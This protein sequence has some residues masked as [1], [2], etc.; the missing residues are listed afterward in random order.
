VPARRPGGPQGSPAHKAGSLRCPYY[1]WTYR[2]EGDLLKAPWSEEIDGFDQAGFG[3]HPVGV[4]TW[5]GFVFLHLTPREA[6]P[7]ADQ[8]GPVPERLRRYPLAELSVGRRELQRVLPLRRR[9][10]GAVP[11]RAR[12]QARRGRP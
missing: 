3:L 2:L 6:V 4:A 11:G 1:S 10:P 9:P 5:G 7:L 12:V 8:L